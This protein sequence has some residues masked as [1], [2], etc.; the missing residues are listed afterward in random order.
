M[1]AI[2]KTE[3]NFAIQSCIKVLDAVNTTAS[4][5]YSDMSEIQGTSKMCKWPVLG[6][7]KIDGKIDLKDGPFMTSLNLLLTRRILLLLK[8]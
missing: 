5:I 8:I 3:V 1:L 2:G 6:G 4:Q 7:L